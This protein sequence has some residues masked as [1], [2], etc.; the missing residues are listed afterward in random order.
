MFVYSENQAMADHDSTPTS[1]PAD[2]SP[3]WRHQARKAAAAVG[4]LLR[5]LVRPTPR[6]HLLQADEV[7]RLYDR[8]APG[9]DALVATYQLLGARRLGTR[10]IELLDLRPGDTVVD[11]GCGT[12]ANL[13]G[14]ARAVGSTGRVVG[15]DLSS[16][17]L[18]QA[19]GRRAAREDGPVELVQA[20]LRRFTLPADTRGVLSTFALE[21]VPEHD[22]VVAR[23]IHILA[24]SGGHLAVS[25]LRRPPDWPEWA[26]C[27]GLAINRP[28]GVSRAYTE[29]HPWKSVR[30]HTR[31]IAFETAVLGA[32]YLCVGAATRH[33]PS[34]A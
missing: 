7:R 19:R 18:D 8:I 28:F 6:D 10:A 20:D 33:D 9:Y 32:V 14:L 13:D 4:P 25:G 2:R 16:G 11:L 5:Q 34:S 29:V 23:T 27:L 30:R 21:M 17:M 31:E 1:Q 24:R 3:G 15:V 26:V 22:E 12:G